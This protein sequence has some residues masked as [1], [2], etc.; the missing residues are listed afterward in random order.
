MGERDAKLAWFLDSEDNMHYSSLYEI[1]ERERALKD[2]LFQA[3]FCQCTTVILAKV[4]PY[5]P[6]LDIEGIVD[7]IAEQAY[8]DMGEVAEDWLDDVT[9]EEFDMLRERMQPIFT[10]WLDEIGATPEFFTVL[11]TEE[12][13]VRDE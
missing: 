4:E 12:I 11:S 8:W 2:A 9:S 10:Q 5:R 6:E 13:E 7:G 3:R 1:G